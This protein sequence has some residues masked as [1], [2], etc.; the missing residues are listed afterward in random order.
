MEN[1]QKEYFEK[2][3]QPE[4]Q[5][6]NVISSSSRSYLKNA[7]DNIPNTCPETDLNFK[8]LE[9]R[10]VCIELE[11]DLLYRICHQDCSKWRA[12]SELVREL[13]IYLSTL[14]KEEEEEGSW[15]E[16]PLEVEE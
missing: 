9:P 11:E 12:C 13:Q 7:H 4:T 1:N 3:A 5:E 15:E 8:F 6:A 16:N 2:T 10:V 14:E